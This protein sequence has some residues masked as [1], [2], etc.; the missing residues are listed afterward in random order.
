MRGAC[1]HLQEELEQGHTEE[2]ALIPFTQDKSFVSEKET[3]NIC[4]FHA[5]DAKYWS[6]VSQILLLWER[7]KVREMGRWWG[8]LTISRRGYRD[9]WGDQRYVLR[10]TNSKQANHTAHPTVTQQSRAESL[11]IEHT[12]PNQWDKTCTIWSLQVYRYD[13]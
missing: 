3:P 7:G 12:T 9:P 1:Q 4:L 10:S 11:F 8:A 5:W 13:C 2:S 6:P